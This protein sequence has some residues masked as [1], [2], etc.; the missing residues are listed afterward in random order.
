MGSAP[1]TIKHAG[2]GFCWTPD[3]FDPPMVA[4]LLTVGLL[5]IGPVLLFLAARRGRSIKGLLTYGLAAC[6]V[7]LLVD[8]V[9]F[10]WPPSARFARET[11]SAWCG[12]GSG[13]LI[14]AGALASAGLLVGLISRLI[15][16]PRRR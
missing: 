9:N 7:T 13:L 16:K 10:G 1:L 2:V 8:F 6:L 5:L 15:W 12:W 3:F 4:K 14:F 11:F